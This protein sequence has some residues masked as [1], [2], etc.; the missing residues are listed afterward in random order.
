M[1]QLKKKHHGN[2]TSC[3]IHSFILCMHN[4]MYYVCILPWIFFFC[5]LA[6]DLTLLVFWHVPVWLCR[7]IS[8]LMW[9]YSWCALVCRT[10]C[11][12]IAIFWSTKTPG[13]DQNEQ[14]T[15]LTCE[16]PRDR[17]QVAT[18]TVGRCLLLAETIKSDTVCLMLTFLSRLLC[19]LYNNWHLQCMGWY[20]CTMPDNNHPWGYS[21]NKISDYQPMMQ[22]WMFLIFFLDIFII[23]TSSKRASVWDGIPHGMTFLVIFK[24][25]NTW[26][27]LVNFLQ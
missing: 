25:Y 3:T 6:L 9:F 7:L 1:R 21:S 18:L 11:V 4:E 19:H 8:S 5:V 2:K 24:N 16:L 12:L 15:W 10:V 26:I 14:S 17:K 22:P 13:H 27:S 20:Y 23:A